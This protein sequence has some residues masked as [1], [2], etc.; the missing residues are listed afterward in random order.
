MKPTRQS[1]NNYVKI[2]F[3]DIGVLTKHLKEVALDTRSHNPIYENREWDELCQKHGV[4]GLEG[5]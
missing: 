1:T 2:Q 4:Y 5:K 3:K